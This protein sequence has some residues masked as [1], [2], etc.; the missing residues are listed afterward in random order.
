MNNHM[1]GLSAVCKDGYLYNR[2]SGRVTVAQR[3]RSRLKSSKP[4]ASCNVIILAYCIV[5]IPLL[6]SSKKGRTR[7]GPASSCAICK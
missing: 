5:I 2:V 7:A 1:V 6:R 4:C 3:G